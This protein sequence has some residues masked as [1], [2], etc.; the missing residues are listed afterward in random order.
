MRARIAERDIKRAGCQLGR[1][2]Y[3]YSSKLRHDRVISQRPRSG[4]VLPSQTRVHLV[5]SR[6]RRPRNPAARTQS[7]SGGRLAHRCAG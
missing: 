1:V 4:A 6:G 2:N 5:I 3:R 7:T